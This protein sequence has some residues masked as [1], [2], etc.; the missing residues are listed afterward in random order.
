MPSETSQPT[1]FL[2]YAHADGKRAQQ[3]AAALTARGYMV[4]WDT[5]IEGG[6]SFAKSIREAL[7]AADAVVV[8]WSKTSVESDWVADEAAQGRDRKRLVPLSLD[9]SLPPLGFRQYQTIDLSGWRGKA[10]AAQVDSIDR[11]IG[12]A[13]GG[14]PG[15]QR[16]AQAP[17]VDRR[18]ALLIA[19]G[20]GVALAGG[21]A[22]YAWRDNWF[23]PGAGERTIAV[24]PFKNLSG[25]TAQAYLSDG[26]TEEVRAALTRNAGLQVLAATTSNT[27]R[28]H[29]EGATQ[30]AGKLGVAHLL[31]GSVQRAGDVVRVAIELTNGKTGF[32]TWSKRIDARLTDIFAFQTEIART[33]S[34]ALSVR[35][36]T[37]DPAPGGTRNVAAYES[38]LRGKALYNLSKDEKTDR[39]AKAQYENAI[40]A[41]P[42][43][44][45]AHAAL[46]RVLSSIASAY[47]PGSEIKQTFAQAIAE[48]R[49][50]VALAPKLAEAHLALG[51]AIFAGKLDI[52]NSRASYDAA[53]LHGRGNADNLLLYALYTVRARRSKEARAA[54]ERAVALD[55]LNPRTHRAAGIIGFATRDYAGGAL[56]FRRALELN[57]AMSNA[58]AFLAMSLIETGKLDEARA[59]IAKEPS[60][61]FRLT[62]LAVLEN[63]AGNQAAAQRAYDQL[64]ADVGDSALYQ[65]AEVMAQFGRADEALVLLRQARAVG[66]SGLTAIAS[67]PLLDP[68]AKDPRFQAFVRELGFA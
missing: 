39:E 49:K 50:A 28:D 19:G 34:E 43:F 21:G 9:G 6:A 38:Y 27:A 2:S 61:M 17:T 35:M 10:A 36:A 8:L 44:G 24:L 42:D 25:D 64:V 58:N 14:T 51:Y 66:D 54:I 4:W 67:D 1:I 33:V 18:S 13:I 16:V 32:S 45:L 22:L 23:G 26:L 5:L 57:P 52:K 37:Q 29:Q 47:A 12:A 31:E 60:A 30:I 7:E 20:A 40:A 15:V 68:I 62:A 65:Q 3:L 46:S 11:A 41:D 55:P 63:R 59:L 53:Y 48:G 56:H